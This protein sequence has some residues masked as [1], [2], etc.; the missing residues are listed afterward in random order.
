MRRWMTLSAALCFGT[1][2]FAHS[3]VKDP[4][5]MARMHVMED[6]ARETKALSAYAN[7]SVAFDIAQVQRIGQALSNHA[8]AS[9]TLFKPPATDPKSEA[10]AIIWT[11]WEGFV[12]ANQLMMDAAKS[13]QEATSPEALQASF[14]ALG[15]SCKAC[16][17]SYRIA[18]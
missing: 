6:I 1:A 17:K 11:D 18:K 2:V 9:L 10:K 8:Q 3:G 7:G 4:Q 15:Q 5:V 12:A 14:R 16:H 13:V